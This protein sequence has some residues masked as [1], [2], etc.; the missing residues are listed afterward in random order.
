MYSRFIIGSIVNDKE[1][2]RNGKKHRIRFLPAVIYGDGE[3]EYWVN[4]FN[5][6][7][8][9]GVLFLNSECVGIVPK[10]I[11]KDGTRSWG[12][13]RMKGILHLHRKSGPAVIYGNGDYEYWVYGKRHGI[14]SYCGKQ[15][16]FKDGEFVKC[17][18]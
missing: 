17:I 4:G 8:E 9:D 5:Y 18:V 6:I 1:W 14:T 2:Y 16:L 7:L 11:Y 15:Y 3:V 10:V 12:R 13:R